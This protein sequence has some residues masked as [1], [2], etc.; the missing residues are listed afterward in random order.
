MFAV[1]KT[2]ISHSAPI[3]AGLWYSASD[4]QTDWGLF[5]Y[6]AFRAG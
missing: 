6:C 3:R 5:I 2:D 4:P 1:L